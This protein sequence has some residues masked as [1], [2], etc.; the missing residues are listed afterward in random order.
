[1]AERE[2]ANTIPTATLAH[3]SG[4]DC[5]GLIE[6]A[7][8][9]VG[10]CLSNGGHSSFWRWLH[11][12]SK[13]GPHDV[14]LRQHHLA[15]GPMVSDCS[16]T[17]CTA[18]PALRAPPDPSLAPTASWLAASPVRT[19]RAPDNLQHCAPLDAA[20]RK[21]E[22]RL[23]LLAT[24]SSTPIGSCAC[25]GQPHLTPCLFEQVNATAAHR[26]GLRPPRASFGP[27]GV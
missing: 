14:A 19:R 6:F 22:P 23:G 24:W 8:Q 21:K 26:P 27:C 15:R 4:V 3:Y 1:M 11:H 2:P 17:A 7:E 5:S 20:A 9:I 16:L 10:V 13:D 25:P 18:R 12:T